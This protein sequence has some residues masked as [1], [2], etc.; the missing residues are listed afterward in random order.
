MN[1]HLQNTLGQ[2]RGRPAMEEIFVIDERDDCHEKWETNVP[3]D[4]GMFF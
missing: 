4:E 2:A 3:R 1:R